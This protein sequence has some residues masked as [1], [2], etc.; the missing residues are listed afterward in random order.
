MKNGTEFIGQA[1]GA[2]AALSLEKGGEF[3]KVE[4]PKLK[5][6]LLE[7]NAYLF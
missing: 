3:A 4:Y 1:A 5:K 7:Q 2:A 6:L